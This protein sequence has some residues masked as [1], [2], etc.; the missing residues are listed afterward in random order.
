M[1]DTGLSGFHRI[2]HLWT[3]RKFVENGGIAQ[4]CQEKSCTAACRSIYAAAEI[5]PI[6]EPD[7]KVFRHARHLPDTN[8]DMKMKKVGR[9]LGTDPNGT[10][11]SLKFR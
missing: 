1:F 7:V 11:I 5:F 8:G 10:S 4:S 3:N 9:K 6:F 2:L